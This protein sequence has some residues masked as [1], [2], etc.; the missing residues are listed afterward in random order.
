MKMRKVLALL[1][2][3]LLTL[4][5][6]A[7]AE[8]P[9]A[10]EAPVAEEAPEASGET[11]ADE[12]PVIAEFG[13]VQIRLSDALLRFENYYQMLASYGIDMSVY[14]DIVKQQVVSELVQ[15]A[16]EAYKTEE[17]GYNDLTGEE[18]EQAA[19]EAESQYQ[20]LYDYYLSYF[21]SNG[22]EDPAAETTAFLAEYGY[23]QDDI[24]EML[25]QSIATN[26][27]ATELTRDVEV[28]EEDLQAG[29]DEEVAADQA[30]YEGNYTAYETARSG[31]S[32]EMFAW[33]PEGYRRVRQVLIGFEDDDRAAYTA[34]AN[35]L[36]KARNGEEGARSEEEIQ[37]EIDALYAP[38]YETAADVRAA[39]DA[40]T[41]IDDLITEYGSDPGML[42][43]PGLTE[44]Y[45]V[46][47]DSQQWDTAFRDAAMSV[48]AIGELSEPAPGT[49]GLYMVYY[50]ADVTP[51][52]VPLD[53]LRDTLSAQLLS[54]AQTTA[55]H[56]QL[57]AWR[58]ELGVEYH[59]ENFVTAYDAN[60]SVV[61]STETEAD[62]GAEAETD[63][64]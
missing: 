34:L 5:A 1:L 25:K 20:E 45:Y 63:G 60:N 18:L 33:N 46:C 55:Y 14:S 39:F 50:L 48:N 2:A 42:T 3:L 32:D 29:Y 49:Y 62:A 40:G 53:E 4:S 30:A 27:M 26:N 13:D 43:E 17:L 19:A 64:E 8:E 15:Q 51:G 44:G 10:T 54:E 7:F 47:A 61:S 12:D 28:T 52:A 24:L 58:E 22:V 23:S 16:I 36:V 35:E 57:S 6:V 41:S 31:G 59:L 37:A 21:T 38:L 11:A 56:A 9:E